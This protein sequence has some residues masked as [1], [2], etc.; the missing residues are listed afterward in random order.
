MSTSSYDDLA[1]IYDHFQK[2][3]DPILW[4]KYID[5]L[6]RQFGPQKGDGR[7]GRL[8]L[9]DL[10]CGTGGVSVEMHAL[11]YDVIGIDESFLM[12]ERAREKAKA[13][14]ADILFLMQDMTRMELF[15]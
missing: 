14:G 1:Q 8:L 6:I 9:C 2:D 10:G 5:G 4:A 13:A 7:G 11:G 15:G 12:L 3:I